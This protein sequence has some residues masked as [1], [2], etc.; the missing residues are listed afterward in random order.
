MIIV[1]V[2]GGLGNQLFQ[3]AFGISFS[4]KNDCNV[5]F[6]INNYKHSRLSSDYNSAKPHS[7]YCLKL[8][9]TKVELATDE[10]I[11]KIRSMDSKLV[12][13][14]ESIKDLYRK[15]D[16]GFSHYI[17][18][19]KIV[20]SGVYEPGLFDFNGDFYFSGY[21]QSEK[22]FSDYKREFLNDFTLDIKLDAANMKMLKQIKSTNSVS[23]HIRRGDYLKSDIWL[24]PQS[25]YA[26]AI[27]HILSREKKLHFYI[28]SNDIDWVMKNIKI[29]APYSVV[30]INPPNKGYFDLELMRHCKH[31]IIANSSFSWWGAWLNKNPDKI[32]L[33]PSPW[34]KM[35]DRFKDII[36]DSWIKIK[37]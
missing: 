4:R 7:L 16:T 27:K 26:D 3:Y 8:Y 34:N 11:R 20:G 36:S 33:A 5:L 24:L 28:F 1:R 25:Y 18:V 21:F 6:D 19:P 9:K 35:T 15:S 2:S 23:L 13:Q 10:Q 32:V 29:D 17:E 30:D 14:P 31:N 37:H 12:E 22:Y